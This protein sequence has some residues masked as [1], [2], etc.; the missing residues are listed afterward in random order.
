[1]AS[2]SPWAWTMPKASM[3]ASVSAVA[4]V[5]IVTRSFPALSMPA[6]HQSCIDAVA[7]SAACTFQTTRRTARCASACESRRRLTP[8][9]NI[10][11]AWSCSDDSPNAAQRFFLNVVLFTGSSPW[12]GRHRFRRCFAPLAYLPRSC[13]RRRAYRW[14]RLVVLGHDCPRSQSICQRARTQEIAVAVSYGEDVFVSDVTSSSTE[15]NRS[16]RMQP[17]RS[18]RESLE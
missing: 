14:A 16:S 6:S 8:R 1:M 10:G 7:G 5:P 13:D 12:R 18:R 17:R 3:P 9:E 15:L 2:W 4:C 11:A